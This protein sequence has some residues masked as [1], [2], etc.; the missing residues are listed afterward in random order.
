MGNS[1]EVKE[2]SKTIPLW[3][4][5]AAWPEISLTCFYGLSTCYV[6]DPYAWVTGVSIGIR[7]GMVEVARGS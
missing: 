2:I 3:E 4:S 5:G 6:P 1:V 7:G